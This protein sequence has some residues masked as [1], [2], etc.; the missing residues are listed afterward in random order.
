MSV[1]E[2]RGVDAEIRCRKRSK[3]QGNRQTQQITF[4]MLN[5]NVLWCLVD[6]DMHGHQEYIINMYGWFRSD[7][8]QVKLKS[9][10]NKVQGCYIT[11]NKKQ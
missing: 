3:E 9:M 11:R 4:S 8:S 7:P 2:T 10:L 5:L 1:V 6:G